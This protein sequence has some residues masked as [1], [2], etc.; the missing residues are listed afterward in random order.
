[1]TV[2]ALGLLSP[3]L[4]VL[5][6]ALTL[7]WLPERVRFL[8][9]PLFDVVALMAVGIILIGL[10]FRPTGGE[11]VLAVV[12][13]LSL[14]LAYALLLIGVVA[15]SPTL[16]LINAIADYGAS[17]MPL[18]KLDEFTRAH[19]FLERRTEA[20]LRSGLLRREG[21]VL[22]LRGNVGLGLRLGE[23]YRHLCRR[24]AIAG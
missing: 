9:I 14:S 10:G 15:D 4:A 16:A 23:A 24:D 19:P 22:F 18:T 20:L 6:H 2:A 3:L 11:W 7:S 8:A 17:G 1:M 5:M 21:G 12:L 13:T